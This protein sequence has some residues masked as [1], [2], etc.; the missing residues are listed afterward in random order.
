MFR[1]LT[2]TIINLIKIDTDFYLNE[3]AMLEVNSQIV[4][5]LNRMLRSKN[6]KAVRFNAI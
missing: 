6:I 3:I 5:V 4:F 2:A 1:L